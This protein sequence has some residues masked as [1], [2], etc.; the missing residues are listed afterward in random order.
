M[1]SN[2]GNS[3]FAHSWS[4]QTP[5]NEQINQNYGQTNQQKHPNQEDLVISVWFIFVFYIG[6]SLPTCSFDLMARNAESSD[7]NIY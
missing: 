3:N 7:K 4:K 1:G 6:V 5:N 2:V